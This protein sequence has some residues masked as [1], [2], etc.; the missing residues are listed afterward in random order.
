MS[1][2]TS[3]ANANVTKTALDKVFFQKYAATPGPKMT[4]AA[5]PAVFNQDSTDRSAVIME[6][7]KGV[8]LW[9]ATPEQAEYQGDENETGN[10][11][12]YSVARYTKAV[13]ITE[14]MIEDDLHSVVKQNI[15]MAGTRGRQTQDEKSAAIFKN[16]AGT[17]LT[18]DGVALLSASH[19]NLNGDTVSNLISGVMTNDTIEEGI[20]KLVE[21]VDQ[22]GLIVG[23]EAKTLLVPPAL[24]REAADIIDAVLEPNSTENQK[25]WISNNYGI[26]LKQSNKI[27]AANGGSDTAFF[28]MGEFHTVMRWVRIPIQ[29]KLLSGDYQA[30]G[31]SVFRGRF[32]EV[33]GA[34]TYEALVGYHA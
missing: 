24:F 10:Q 13:H 33:Y 5:D 21:Q 18:S 25:N 17:T 26:T 15:A 11:I 22:T 9:S 3:G 34:I 14:E 32:R 4:Y 28:M 20:N 7:N 29:T 6:V 27:G 31:D 23:H 8:G 12:T 30:N 16:A 19:S 2:I 1:G